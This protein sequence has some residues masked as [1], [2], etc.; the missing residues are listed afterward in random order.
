MGKNIHGLKPVSLSIILSS[1]LS[2]CIPDSVTFAASS[3]AALLKAQKD[4]EAKGY[5]FETSRDEIVAKARKEARVRVLS[6]MD[7]SVIRALRDGFKKKYAF[8]DVRAEELGS[9]DENQRFLLEIKAGTAR[10][11]DVNRVYTELYEE[12][13]PYQ[14]KFDILG[15]AEHRVLN[16]PPVF[17]DPRPRSVVNVSSNMTVIAYNKKLLPAD[18]VPETWEDFLKPEYKG[19]KFVVDIRPLPLAMLVPTWGLERTVDFARKLAAQEPVW[20][21]GHTRMIASVVNGEHAL[22]LGPNLGSVKNAQEKDRAGVL[23]MKIPEPVPTRLHEAN[24]VLLTADYPYAALLWLEFLSSP[25]GQKIL[26]E[27]WPVG[28]SFL[29][30]GSVQAQ[31]TKG[32]KLSVVDWNH[33]TKLDDYLGKVVEAFGF[34]KAK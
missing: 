3:S 1:V 11:W 10:G 28:A 12:F 29:F 21:R 22:F 33:I 27:Q 24:G 9:V 6:T 30:P 26:D 17:V 4:A 23:A 31:L 34:P 13:L 25:E 15:M 19:K 16:I 20:G 2:L 32:K 7:L 14:K 18:K 8:I 5:I